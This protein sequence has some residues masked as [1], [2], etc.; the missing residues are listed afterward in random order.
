MR[1][2][3]R[4][5][6]LGL[7][8]VYL[9]TPSSYHDARGGFF[10]NFEERMLLDKGIK[11]YFYEEFFTTSKKGVIRGLH[12]QRG[13]H[14]QAKFIWCFKGRIFDVVVDL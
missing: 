8:G 7:S 10:K 1:T 11:P 5:E 12:Y 4:A 3:I 13:E 9:I 6:E 2:E 14:S